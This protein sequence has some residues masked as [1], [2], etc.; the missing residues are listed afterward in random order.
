MKICVI[1]PNFPS[2]HS[3][4]F[5]FLEQLCREFADMGHEVVVVTRQSLTNHF[6]RRTPLVKNYSEVRTERGNIIKVFRPRIFTFGNTRWSVKAMNRCVYNTLQ[7]IGFQ[8]DVIYGHF[9]ESAYAGFAYAREHGIPLFAV[10]G[11]DYITLQNYIPA[12]D[13]TTLR[14]YVS[15]VVCVS[16]KSKEESIAMGFAVAEKCTVI[17]N[18]INPKLFRKLDKDAMRAKYN[19]PSSDFVVSFVGQFTERKGVLRICEALKQIG[20]DDIK[21]MFIGSGPQ[22]PEYEHILLK[23]KVDHDLIP[24]YLNCADVFVLPTYSEGCCNAM[25]E[26]MACG[27]PVISSDRSFNWDVLNAGNSIL[28]EPDSIDDIADSICR[29]HDDFGYRHL[30]SEASLTTAAG[31]TLDQRARRIVNFITSRI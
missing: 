24:E 6:V 15:G 8:P 30:L 2:E 26:A 25:I 3:I 13:V 5:M 1:S 17:P 20:R 9:W 27:L 23:G 11:E 7:N 31:L 10:A 14:D 28:I 21:A 29:L 18:A 4:S 16:S 22:N 12:S 19:I